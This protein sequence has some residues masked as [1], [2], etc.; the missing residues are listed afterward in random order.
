[1]G[2]VNIR[3]ATREEFSKVAEVFRDAFDYEIIPI[4][5]DAL[6]PELHDDIYQFLFI[7][8]WMKG[9]YGKLLR[10]IGIENIGRAIKDMGGGV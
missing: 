10:S 6:S 1:M 7:M 5:G 9:R 3:L 2:K 4:F 8:R